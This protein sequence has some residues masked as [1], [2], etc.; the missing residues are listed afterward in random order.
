MTVTMAVTIAGRG[1]ATANRL[2]RCRQRT[3][4]SAVNKDSRNTTADSAVNETAYETQNKAAG[5]SRSGCS[6]AVPHLKNRMYKIGK[7][8]YY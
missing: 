1:N 8:V 2:Q 7:N 5:F 6:V 3:A 4:N